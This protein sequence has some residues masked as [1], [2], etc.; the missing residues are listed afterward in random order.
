MFIHFCLQSIR[1]SHNIHSSTIFIRSLTLKVCFIHI[2][3]QL[4]STLLSHLLISIGTPHIDIITSIRHHFFRS[5]LLTPPL[6]LNMPVRGLYGLGK[7]SYGHGFAHTLPVPALCGH[8]KRVSL[9]S[10]GILYIYFFFF[11][12]FF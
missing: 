4:H 3:C 6:P 11:F 7:G 1:L 8:G 2:Y 9:P 10:G 12:F 5:L